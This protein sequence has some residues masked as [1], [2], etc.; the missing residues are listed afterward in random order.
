MRVIQGYAIVAGLFRAPEPKVQVHYCDQAL[1][2]V[3][4]SVVNF[5]HFWLL[6]WTEFNET[7]QEARPQCP[8]P[9]LCFS[10]R[11]EKTRWPPWPL[12]CWEIFN[13]PFETADRNSTKLDWK[14]DLNVLYRVCVFR[15]D[16]KTEMATLA[17]DWW[18]RIYCNTWLYSSPTN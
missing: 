12:I 6:L 1:S 17:S 10:G 8:L 2:V 11:S 4:P 15:V 3:R 18:R 13:F 5:S 9:S 14:Q 7:R 16:I